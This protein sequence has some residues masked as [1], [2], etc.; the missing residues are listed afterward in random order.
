ML[1]VFFNNSIDQVIVETDA[2]V[3]VCGV[4]HAMKWHLLK[5]MVASKVPVKPH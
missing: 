4:N 3:S 2:K 5:K 1:E